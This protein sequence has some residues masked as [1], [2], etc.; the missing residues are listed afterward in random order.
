MDLGT[1]KKRIDS[2]AYSTVDDV[3]KDVRR[4]WLNAFTYNRKGSPVYKYAQVL[5]KEFSKMI[6]KSKHGTYCRLCVL[7]CCSG[8]PIP[9]YNIS[10]YDLGGTG[11]L[12]ENPDVCFACKKVSKLFACDGGCGLLY[13]TKCAGLVR[14]PTV[15]QWYCLS[16][17]KENP[18]FEQA[19]KE[20]TSL[21]APQ[22]DPS[23]MSLTEKVQAICNNLESAADT[24]GRQIAELFVELPSMESY[25]DYYQI[26]QQPIS[27]E[28]IR[29][30]TYNTLEDFR[31][32]FQLLV[33]NA[34]TY[35][36]P[37]SQVYR[38]A[39]T[40][41]KLFNT[42]LAKYFPGAVTSPSKKRELH[43]ST[44]PDQSEKKLQL[45]P[46]KEDQI[47]TQPLTNASQL[48]D[49]QSPTK[50]AQESLNLTDPEERY[51]Q[52]VSRQESLKVTTT[53]TVI[54][55][56][57]QAQFRAAVRNYYQR[58][59]ITGCYIPEA[60]QAAH[61][62]D[63]TQDDASWE[64]GLLL[65]SDIHNLF[66]SNL[67]RLTPS[68]ALHSADVQVVLLEQTSEYYKDLPKTIQ[69]TNLVTRRLLKLR[70]EQR[71]KN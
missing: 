69:I 34:Q 55:R 20:A 62:L 71:F 57:S 35:N 25:P 70:D 10:G 50:A 27:L 28:E 26:I 3:I 40:L 13:H 44:P 9:S 36:K 53:R 48:P 52:I 59:V 1:I 65:R 66:D 8:N 39:S 54:D 18:E 6:S 12:P 14:A 33:K 30:N 68:D 11:S 19:M 29:T 4:V 56:P 31:K 49:V 2:N 24:K 46:T 41:E 7:T 45:S 63:H 38:D 60:C 32:D 21:S 58:C 67:L 16:C 15:Q 61:I 47:A 43:P 17:Q 23:V 5:S 22:K 37:K 51:R 64:N 42:E